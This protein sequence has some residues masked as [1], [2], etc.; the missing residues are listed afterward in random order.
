MALE[1]VGPFEGR[2]AAG[3]FALEG[4]VLQ[5]GLPIERSARRKTAQRGK[6]NTSK[7]KKKKKEKKIEKGCPLTTPSAQLAWTWVSSRCLKP[8]R[9][10]HPGWSQRKLRACACFRC[11]PRFSLEEKRSTQ[12]S[13]VQA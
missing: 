2:A 3:E 4:A 5:V 13:E 12:P 11:L 1:R 7:M 9:F 6:R 10:P 8:K